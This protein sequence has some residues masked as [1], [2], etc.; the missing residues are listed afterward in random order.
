M[1]PG[2]TEQPLDDSQHEMGEPDEDTTPF[3][4]YKRQKRRHRS[5]T[6]SEN[7]LLSEMSSINDLTV[8]LKPT[9]PMK[10]VTKVNPLKLAEYLESVAPDGILQIR[11]NPRLNLLALDTRNMDST[12]ALLAVS[13]VCGIPVQAYQPRSLDN[14][15]G[16]IRDLPPDLSDDEILK[17]TRG[18]VVLKVRRLGASE[19]V[20]LVFKAPT[21]PEHV[22]VGYTRYKVLPYIEKPRQ[23]TKC[24][25][26]GH[27][28]S[29]CLMAL[30]C[31]RCGKDHEREKC[32]ADQPRCPNCKRGHEST[33]RWCPSFKTEEAIS[34]V[35]SE[36]RMDYV[37]AR[38]V[39]VGN[40]TSRP[41]VQR[42]KS[43]SPEH[44]VVDAQKEIQE[45]V[46]KHARAT[47]PLP[48]GN[49][50]ELVC[51]DV[52]FPP[53]SK[54]TEP[55]MPAK[56]TKFSSKPTKPSRTDSGQD[57]ASPPN[58][59]SALRSIL[60]TFRGMLQ[61]LDFPFAKSIITLVDAVLP[62]TRLF[63]C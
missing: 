38:A 25:R 24:H 37:S 40:A 8:I 4:E 19:A 23:C 22:C 17:A 46:S 44:N 27:I 55:Q 45:G 63:A 52:N 30:R 58:F 57:D 36:K 13:V 39:I 6:S 43:S 51:D 60:S 48:E 12:K 15:V 31:V 29:T 21:V 5:G 49:A 20:Q 9:D 3:T 59:G 33:S 10:L 50:P 28:A 61:M 62:L 7:I 18:S 47:N 16:V 56:N 11:P 1:E 54:H 42:L 41:R 2:L 26:F 34:K 53:L 35:R 14:A 32:T